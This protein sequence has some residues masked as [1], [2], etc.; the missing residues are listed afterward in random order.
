[1][2]GTSNTSERT[3]KCAYCLKEIE[4]EEYFA[5]DFYHKECAEEQG[6]FKWRTT[7]TPWRDDERDSNE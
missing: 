4:S 7:S 6:K 1:M 3:H 2:D 5:N